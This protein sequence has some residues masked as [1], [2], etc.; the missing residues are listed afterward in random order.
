[1]SLNFL[2]RWMRTLIPSSENCA[3]CQK[4]FRQPRADAQAADTEFMT[5][6]VAVRFKSHFLHSILFST[7]RTWCLLLYLIALSITY[8]SAFCFLSL[9]LPTVIRAL[10]TKKDV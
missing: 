7:Q 3:M 2:F 8:L 5:R 10:N 9:F 6:I 1:M 4:A